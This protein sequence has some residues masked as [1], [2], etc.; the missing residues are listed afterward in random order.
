[1]NR[2]QLKFGLWTALI[3]GA[4]G[5]LIAQTSSGTIA[6]T[7]T[8]STGAA[9]GGA[10]VTAVSNDT[11]ERRS[12]TANGVGGYRIESVT[13][14]TFVVTAQAPSFQKT[15]TPNVHVSASVVTSVNETLNVGSTSETVEVPADQVTLSTD[16][17]AVT[18]TL[19]AVAVDNLP[20][21]GLNPYFLALTLPGVQTVNAT[22][23]SN[24]INFSVNGIRSRANNFLIEGSDNNDAGIHGQGL[25]PENLDAIEQVVVLENAYQAEFGGG[26]GSVS[27]LIYKNG[28]NHFHG[29]VWDRI[30]NSSLDA[31]DKSNFYTSGFKSKY[32]EN[33]FG[34]DIGGYAIKDKLFF[35]NSLQ[36]D[37]YRSSTSSTLVVPT[38]TGVATL[39]SLGTNPRVA[40]LLQAIGSLRGIDDPNSPDFSCIPIT[41]STLAT[42]ACP[43]G[44]VAVGPAVR[45]IPLNTNAPELDA[46]V[47]YIPNQ[48]DTIV[49]RY[50]RT[51][52]NAPI[53]GFNYPSQLPGFDATENGESHNAGIT[54]THIFTP[55]LLNDLRLSYGRIGF[56]FDFAPST[57]ANP[58]GTAP[59]T[60]IPGIT[61]FGAP[62][63]DP[64]SRQ[65]N[66][67]QLQDALSW[68]IGG[69]HAVKVGFD[70]SNVRVRDA[71]PFNFYGSI[72][73]AATAPG[74]SG[75]ANYI[76]DF[77]GKNGS[78]AINYG[79]P[80]ARPQLYNQNYYIQDN[81]KAAEHLTL[82][83]GFRYE[84]EGAPFNSAQYPAFDIT[85]P[86]C[87][88]PALSGT[89]V[90]TF[91][92]IKET[93]DKSQYGPRFGFAYTPSFLGSKTVLRGGFGIFYDGLF[94]NIIDNTQSS[95]PNAASP[96]VISSTSGR[97]LANFSQYLT[98]GSLNK[99]PQL[100]DLV[101]SMTPHILSPRTLQW[102]VNVQQDLGYGFISQIG[103]VGTRG[104]HLY[105]TTESNPIIDP[106]NTGDRLFP[107]RGRILIRDNS[108]D[109]VYHSAQVEINR[110]FTH[111]FYF[112]SAYT[113]S[114]TEDD[115]TEVFTSGNESQ[116]GERQY[117]FPRKQVDY[118]LSS[119]DTRHRLVVTYVYAPPAWHPEGMKKIAS[120]VVNGFQFSGSNVFQSGNPGNI[121]AGY[122]YNGDGISNDRPVLSNPLAPLNTYAFDGPTF[123]GVG[124]LCDGPAG[125]YTNDPCHPVTADQVHFIIPAIGTNPQTIQRNS[126]RT[127]GNQNWDLSIQRTFH[128]HESQNFDFRAEAFNVLNQG[129]TGTPNLTL[130][131]INP[132]PNTYGP[133]A[134]NNFAQTT[135]GHRNLRFYVKYSF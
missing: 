39:Q 61:G 78:V 74:F 17:G 97:G 103:Y 99:T 130:S 118:G 14:G 47:E 125:F 128:I 77:G 126:F 88:N 57:Y 123:F 113:W 95:A 29:A 4:A 135:T 11:G 58:L 117:P 60:S 92:N 107:N 16:S 96:E 85:N 20:I 35:F 87:T 33:L 26:G 116:F 81:W 36:F 1:M 2:L 76:D 121:E 12:V 22:A 56:V 54:E 45:S 28:S 41:E 109:S 31:A 111:G 108:G 106:I 86:A 112:R 102:N 65:H 49:F 9:V 120:Q 40:T 91:C 127:L 27:N 55:R 5:S 119:L 75:L 48:K 131:N 24:G 43:A 23:F 98:N 34:Y 89:G 21:Q 114:K 124:G 71:V 104:E 134:F 80:I 73:Y 19:N 94:T 64:Q 51:T 105:G 133:I 66:T 115:V 72:S 82:E 30:L 8:D 44:R 84:Y 18:G 101:E 3:F 59:T 13:P 129:N 70:V 68:N 38:A 79:N 37:H 53:D 10:T 132:D 90:P 63:G 46:K 62:A 32:R 67:Y 83:L 52:F 25:Q 42:S 100:T 122:D 7:I 15:T 50:I 69:R 93:G 110:S 6:G